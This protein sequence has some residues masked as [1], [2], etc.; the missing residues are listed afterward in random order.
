VIEEFYNS[1][2]KTFVWLYFQTVHAV[3]DPRKGKSQCHTLSLSTSI[4]ASRRHLLARCRVPCV[5]RARNCGMRTTA[6]TSP[7]PRGLLDNS[8]IREPYADL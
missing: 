4:I 8:S 3:W 2:G 7:V 5:L 1:R 6:G